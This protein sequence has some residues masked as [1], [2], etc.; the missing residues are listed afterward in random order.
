ML[1]IEALV[2][3]LIALE[4]GRGVWVWLSTLTRD[5]T[6]RTVRDFFGSLNPGDDKTIEEISAATKLSAKKVGASLNRLFDKLQVEND[7][8]G[9]WRKIRR[10]VVK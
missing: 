9:R 2:L 4:F 3:L 6:D 8:I 1:V 10:Y 7:G 5:T